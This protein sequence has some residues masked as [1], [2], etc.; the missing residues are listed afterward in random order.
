MTSLRLQDDGTQLCE[1]TGIRISRLSDGS[2]VATH[3]QCD[4]DV[5][6]NANGMIWNCY[7]AAID[8]LVDINEM[9]AR[10]D[11]RGER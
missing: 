11:M 5:A 8:A 2:V 7:K 1:R 10:H 4:F 9:V 6:V 3:P